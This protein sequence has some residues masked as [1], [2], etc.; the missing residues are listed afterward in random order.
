MAERVSKEAIKREEGYLYY[1]GKDGYVWQNPTRSN[2]SGRK[3]RIGSEKVDRAQGY[4][5]YVDSNG[6]ISRVPQ[7][8]GKKKK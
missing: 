7:A 2:K 4:L 6:Y 5:Y 1:L 3:A 8:R